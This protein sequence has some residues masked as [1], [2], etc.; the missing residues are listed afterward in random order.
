MNIDWT[1]YLSWTLAVTAVALLLVF[2]VACWAATLAGLPGNW[3][4]LVACLAFDACLPLD[5][6][7]RI[8]WPLLVG[9]AGLAVLGELLEFFAGAAGVRSQGGTRLSALLALVGSVIGGLAGAILGLP[10]PVVGSVLAVLLFASLGALV[11]AA[12]GEDWHGRELGDSLRVGYA[13]F[14]GRLLGSL[15]KTLVGGLM[16][17]VVF[18]GLLL[19]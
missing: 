18:A 5:W 11:G 2:V 17:A 7:I 14:W 12:A 8:A 6:R 9:L 1:P 10:V 16:V 19:P 15:A 3:G 4:I 13:A